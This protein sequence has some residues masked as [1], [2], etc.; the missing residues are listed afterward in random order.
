MHALLFRFAPLGALIVLWIIR[1][2]NG[3]FL[4]QRIWEP[5][6]LQWYYAIMVPLAWVATWAIWPTLA[7]YM[8]RFLRR[9]IAIP[10][11]LFAIIVVILWIVDVAYNYTVGAWCDACP[12]SRFVA[13]FTNVL[14][15][16]R[17]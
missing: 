16:S 4:A 7:L 17:E 3:E 1:A 10:V 5:V 12:D 15:G 14:F 11:V 8:G 6:P 13:S 2:Y 9:G